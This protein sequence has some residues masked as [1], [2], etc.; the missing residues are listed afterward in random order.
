L[1]VIELESDFVAPEPLDLKVE[2]ERRAELGSSIPCAHVTS[3]RSGSCEIDT[4]RE[5]SRESPQVGVDRSPPHP[6]CCQVPTCNAPFI[7]LIAVEDTDALMQTIT[8]TSLVNPK[9]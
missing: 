8:Q 3:S 9:P 7:N 2:R 4:V 1:G 6:K 5:I